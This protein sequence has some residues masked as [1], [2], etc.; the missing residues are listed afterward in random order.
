LLVII[1]LVLL[2][3][4]VIVVTKYSVLIG[5][6]LWM[7]VMLSKFLCIYERYLGFYMYANGRLLIASTTPARNKVTSSGGAQK[8]TE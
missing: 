5:W 2:A 7:L 6:L 3:C 4:R 1:A 8:S